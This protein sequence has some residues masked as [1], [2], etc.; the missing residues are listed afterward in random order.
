VEVPVR[1]HYASRTGKLERAAENRAYLH[2]LLL[3]KEPRFL[4]AL[5]LAVNLV[6]AELSGESLEVLD[7]SALVA[8]CAP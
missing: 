2:V 1:R 6:D 5:E 7:E 4:A 8:Q 3:E